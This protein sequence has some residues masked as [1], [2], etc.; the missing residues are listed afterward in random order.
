MRFMIL[1]KARRDVRA[2]GLPSEQALAELGAFN[3]KLV[4][5]GVMIAVEGLL[6]SSK[7]ARV[8]LTQS[9]RTVT[10]GP[11]DDVKELICGFW[12]W[13]VNSKEEAI[14]WVKRCPSPTGYECEIEIR[15]IKELCDFRADAPRQ[16]QGAH[17]GSSEAHGPLRRAR[18][19]SESRS[20]SLTSTFTLHTLKTRCR[21]SATLSLF[22]GPSRT[23]KRA[24][25][26]HVAI[27]NRCEHA[28]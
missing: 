11:F 1:V 8:Q 10:E 5:A 2:A 20:F 27:E 21:A 6:P 19:A 12:I 15:Q 7:G 26:E 17:P 16:T 24:P 14:D 18:E 9:N 4:K 13:Q 25:Q 23:G 28:L 22:R 3:E